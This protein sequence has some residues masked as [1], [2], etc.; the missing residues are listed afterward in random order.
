MILLAIPACDPYFICIIILIYRL[1][2]SNQNVLAI[3]IHL[4]MDM[5]DIAWF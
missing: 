2:A 5:S 3:Y 1:S 4:F